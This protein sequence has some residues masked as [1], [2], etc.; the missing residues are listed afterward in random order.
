MPLAKMIKAC[1]VNDESLT[2]AVQNRKEWEERGQAIF[3]GMLTKVNQIPEV[4]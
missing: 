2:H 4:V 1:G 3:Q